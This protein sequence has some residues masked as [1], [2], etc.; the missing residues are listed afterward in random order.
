MEL[1]IV[2]YMSKY[3]RCSTCDNVN[4]SNYVNHTKDNECYVTK[5][6]KMFI[7]ESMCTKQLRRSTCSSSEFISFQDHG[8][9]HISRGIIDVDDND[10]CFARYLLC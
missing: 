7:R 10:T 3:V 8:G 9:Q 1:Y 4:P 5:S 2:L 6:V